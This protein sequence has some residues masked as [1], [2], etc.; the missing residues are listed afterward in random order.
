MTTTKVKK[1][2]FEEFLQ[3]YPDDHGIN[4]L[5][6]GE[7]VQVELTRAHKN[8]AR[9]LVKCFDREIDR[10]QLDEVIKS[11]RRATALER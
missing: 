4:E 10:L 9:Y 11:E 3:H 8:V 1:L 5:V 2:T 6:N 7:I